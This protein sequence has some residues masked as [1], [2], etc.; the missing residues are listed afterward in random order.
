MREAPVGRDRPLARFAA[1]LQG[2]Y[3]RA[4]IRE[5]TLAE[6]LAVTRAAAIRA[7]RTAATTRGRVARHGAHR[8]GAALNS[9]WLELAARLAEAASSRVL[10]LRHRS[11]SE[12]RLVTAF[13]LSLVLVSSALADARPSGP[14]GSARGIG[15][16]ESARIAALE[17]LTELPVYGAAGEL[18][19]D[20]L[21]DAGIGYDPAAADA[22]DQSV[23]AMG[24]PYLPDG[25]LLKPVAVDGSFPNLERHD[26]R[27]YR[28]RGGDTLTG[29]A[30]RF[31][32][33]MMT[34]WW[35]NKLTSK[36]RLK[37][38]QEIVIP[39][40][41]GLL[42]TVK[43]GDTLEAIATETKADVEEIRTFNG[44][45]SDT[46]ILGQQLM[47]PGGRGEPIP[48]PKPTPKPAP[49]TGSSG[50][51]YGCSFSGALRWPVAGGY[52]S[53][54]YSS[55]HRAIDIAAN[56]GTSVLA[57]AYGRVIWAGWRSNCGGY[58]IWV[59]HGNGMYTGYYHVS[60]ILAGAGS[61][62]GRGQRIGRVGTSGCTT[63]PHLHFE[64]RIGKTYDTAS[65]VNPLL[66][67]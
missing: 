41:S 15:T 44:L 38:G 42:W 46:L 49:R 36:D 33:S 6:R 26:V 5:P 2:A 25:T 34:L 14:V 65:R 16:A 37:V 61:Y 53:Q 20:D 50:G 30:S 13:V 45:T 47:I 7:I 23:G 54:Y 43:E 35:A 67:L 11:A 8:R 40:V 18:E 3:P 63:G 55:Y 21:I 32:V 22:A 9:Y 57:A 66:Y 19:R 29:I 12:R 17:G 48:T 10:T 64:V 28:V 58:Q 56:Y 27:L 24:A 52:I 39:P 62:V 31:N 51:C 1:D 60:A 4:P 59:S